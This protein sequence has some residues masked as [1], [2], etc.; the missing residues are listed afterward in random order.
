MKVLIPAKGG[1][2]GKSNCK[3]ERAHKEST[4]CPFVILMRLRRFQSF[5]EQISPPV[6]GPPLCRSAAPLLFMQEVGARVHPPPS[7]KQEC[8]ASLSM[9]MAPALRALTGGS[10]SQAR[11]VGERSTAG[12]ALIAGRISGRGVGAAAQARFSS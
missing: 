8:A 6:V 4:F 3:Y 2:L 7:Q 9:L 10:K 5:G 12:V 11:V 1:K